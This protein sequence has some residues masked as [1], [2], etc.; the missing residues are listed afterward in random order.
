MK[1]AA[2]VHRLMLLRHGS[3][4]RSRPGES[5]FDRELEARGRADAGKLGAYLARH[6]LVP[7]RVLVSPAR[8]AHDTW[9]IAAA[10]CPPAPPAHHDPRLYDANAETILGIVKEATESTTV[11]VVGH[12]PGLH[13]LA[14][15]LIASGDVENRERLHENL[16]TAGLVV[17]DFAA[18]AWSKVHP[19]SG[20]LEL[21]LE[22]EALDTAVD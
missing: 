5:D 2:D 10:S 16:P 13:D 20:R 1:P 4:Q 9:A 3:A 7:D 6:Q 17:I 11:L 19:E 22:P 15:L 8:R 14:M 21:F 12:N 18:G